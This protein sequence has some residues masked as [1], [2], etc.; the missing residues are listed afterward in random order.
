MQQILLFY[1]HISNNKSFS[2]MPDL[3]GFS[4]Q[5]LYQS[6]TYNLLYSLQISNFPLIKNLA[7]ANSKRR[8]ENNAEILCFCLSQKMLYK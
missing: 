1:Y 7:V 8:Q 6:S 3:I 4:R 2:I 5:I